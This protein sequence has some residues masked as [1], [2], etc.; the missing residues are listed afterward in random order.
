M[1]LA[2]T[3]TLVGAIATALTA[4]LVTDDGP[5][6]VLALL[7][8]AAAY[9]SYLGAVAAARSYNVAIETVTDLSRFALYRALYVPTPMTGSD[10][11]ETAAALMALLG[12]SSVPDM[13]FL[14]TPD[15]DPTAPSLG[16]SS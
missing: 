5:W 2:I 4:V 16:E 6:A 7:P 3:M 13:Q 9:S 14:G 15:R 12:G 8:F 11:I 1:D 10:E